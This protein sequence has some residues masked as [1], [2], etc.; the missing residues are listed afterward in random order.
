MSQDICENEIKRQIPCDHKLCKLFK[1]SI[2]VVP[3]STLLAYK[4]V[5]NTSIEVKDQTIWVINKYKKGYIFG[6]A[7]TLIN[8]Q[9][10]S[11]TTLIGSITPLGDVLISFHNNNI[12]TSGQGKFIKKDGEWQF[13][14]QMNTLNSISS[15][16]IGLSH[17]SYMVKMEDNDAEYLPGVNLTVH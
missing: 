14:M 8:N 7:Y 11:E 4:T 17:W 2:W 10:S 9:P 15:G 12:I 5:D 13:L 6:T 16:V 3:Q 1:K